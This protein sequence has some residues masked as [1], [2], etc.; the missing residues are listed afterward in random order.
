[1]KLFTESFRNVLTKMALG[2]EVYFTLM[3]RSLQVGGCWYWF[4][5]S[6]VSEPML[7]LVFS[8]GP[9]MAVT[10]LCI[11]LMIKSGQRGMGEANLLLE[12]QSFPRINP[13]LPIITGYHRATCARTGITWTPWWQ[14]RLDK[15]KI[16][17]SLWLGKPKAVLNKI[18]FC[19]PG[20]AWGKR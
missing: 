14:E 12:K 13:P 16:R 10:V 2:R 19:W 6:V 8:Y 17:L 1:M 18:G 4:S 15:L 7:L 20:T 11:I 9:R 3:S 5:S